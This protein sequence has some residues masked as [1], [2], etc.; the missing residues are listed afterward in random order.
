MDSDSGRI[1]P[2]VFE[3]SKAQLKADFLLKGRKLL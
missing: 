1:G 3:R 2:F